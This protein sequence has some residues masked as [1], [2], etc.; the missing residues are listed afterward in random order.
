M[1]RTWLAAA[2]LCLAVT[3]AGADPRLLL[4]GGALAEDGVA[5]SDFTDLHAASPDRLVFRATSDAIFAIEPGGVRRL[6]A[7]GDP[8]PAPSQPRS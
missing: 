5:V 7:S 1:K 6:I 8:L 2:V 4:R 3:A